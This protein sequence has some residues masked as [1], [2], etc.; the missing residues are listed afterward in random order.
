MKHSGWPPNSPPSRGEFE[1]LRR[2]VELLRYCLSET[3]D[4]V[5]RQ[6]KMHQAIVELVAVLARQEAA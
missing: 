2:D 6:T 1:A 3:I 5:Q 4:H